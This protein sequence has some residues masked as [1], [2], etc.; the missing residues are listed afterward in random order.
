[1]LAAEE[2]RRA[3]TGST[4]AGRGPGRRLDLRRPPLHAARTGRRSS[5]R[6]GRR[7]TTRA[8]RPADIGYV[9][10]H[11]T[12]TPK[13]DSVEI[14]CL[15]EVFGKALA[16]IPVSSNKSQIGHTLGAAAAIEAALTIE[17]MRQGI[18]LPTDQPPSRSRISTTWTCVPDQARRQPLRDRPVQRLRLRRHQLLHRLPG[19]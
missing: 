17:G 5:G 6:S 12:S 19:V 4:A 7:S 16:T 9:N 3:A 14:D 18:I 2:A 15:R 10:A 8:S 1:M 13:G 11:G